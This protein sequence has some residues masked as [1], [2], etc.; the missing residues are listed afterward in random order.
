MFKTK[1]NIQSSKDWNTFLK[2][3]KRIPDFIETYTKAKRFP[4]ERGYVFVQEYI[5]NDG[6]DLKVVVVGNKLS[7]LARDVRKGDFRASGGGSIHYDKRLITKEI[8]NISF[9]IAE[10]LGF[11]CMGYDFVIDKR[12]GSPKIVEIS[13]GFPHTNQMNLGGY[14]DKDGVWY[15]QPLNAPQEVLENMLRW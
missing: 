8:R 12:D 10:K 11:Q 9:E 15:D 14:W 1:S 5:P 3:I 4:R 2:R 6:Y 13:Y 7:F